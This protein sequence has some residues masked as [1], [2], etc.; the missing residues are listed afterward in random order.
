MT[1]EIRI[2]TG[3]KLFFADDIIHAVVNSAEL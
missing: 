1:N 3:D 2:E